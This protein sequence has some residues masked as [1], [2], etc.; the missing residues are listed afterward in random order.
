MTL[1]VRDNARAHR[2]E[3]EVEGITSFIDY[4]RHGRVLTLTHTEVP[5]ALGGKGVGTK[6]VRGALDIVR[7]RG[8]TIVVRCDFI[9][10]VIR[11]YPA[12]GDLVAR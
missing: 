11:R 6:L 3:A 7:E 9:D 8:E 5:P 10:A 1:T 12:Y 4:R 2:F